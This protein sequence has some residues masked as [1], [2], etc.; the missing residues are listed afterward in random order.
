MTKLKKSSGAFTLIELMVSIAIIGFLSAIVLVNVNNAKSKS[1]D[2]KRIVDLNQ[3]QVAL[4]FYFD[5]CGEYPAPTT[6]NPPLIPNVAASNGCPTGVTLGTFISQI[7]VPPKGGVDTAYRYV[8]RTDRTDFFLGVR[9]E[10]DNQ[11]LR[12]DF[13][14]TA[15]GTSPAPTPPIW[16]GYVGGTFNAQDSNGV[17]CYAITS[18]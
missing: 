6:S 1:R 5:R 18:K 14:G 9:L 12:D 7:P 2:A 10:N 8:V 3:I 15:G 4:Q 16:E 17:Y 13:D 11:V